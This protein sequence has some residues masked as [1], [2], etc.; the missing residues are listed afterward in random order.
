MSLVQ[1]ITIGR[2]IYIEDDPV[3]DDT[4]LDES[5]LEKARR[6]ASTGN[7]RKSIDPGSEKIKSRHGV[8][9]NCITVPH[10]RGVRYV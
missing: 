4:F 6:E 10:W 9:L 5:D 2:Y 7:F 3:R 1:N 8:Q